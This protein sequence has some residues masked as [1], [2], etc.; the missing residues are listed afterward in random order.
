[1]DHAAQFGRFIR[2]KAKTEQ[3]WMWGYY[4]YHRPLTINLSPVIKS[5]YKRQK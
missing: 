3:A 1:M 2:K 5:S 4:S